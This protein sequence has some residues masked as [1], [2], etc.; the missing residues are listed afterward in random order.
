VELAFIED[1]ASAYT[2]ETLDRDGLRRAGALCSR[3]A[4][5]ELG[6]ADASLAVLA[7]R[8]ST[9]AIA[10]FDERHFRAVAPLDGG[11]FE[12]YPELT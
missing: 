1:L 8:W 11:A 5:L 12:L 4:A 7:E 10:T 9:H 3:Y 6:L 2:V